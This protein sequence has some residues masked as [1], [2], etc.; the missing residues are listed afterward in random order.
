MS[1]PV[2]ATAHPATAGVVTL[3]P[4][5]LSGVA[6]MISLCSAAFTAYL[7][8]FRRPSLEMIVSRQL[9][10][11][12]AANEGLVINAGVTF[13]NSGAKYGVVTSI[14]GE[15]TKVGDENAMRFQWSKF[16]SYENAA[17]VGEGFKP[18]GSFSGWADHLVIPNRQAVANTIQFLSDDAFPL[19]AGK[20][21]LK[22]TAHF[23]SGPKH[24]KLAETRIEFDVSDSK[25]ETL[26]V[27]RVDPETKIS[28]ASVVFAATHV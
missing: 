15:L 10:T 3:M 6:I 17:P 22:L 21:Q 20:Y 19:Q 9:R 26:K 11:W 28:K 5:V 25:L 1:L 8:Y 27:T 4:L 13:T 12:I 14:S 24:K 18:H 23:G 2:P 7:Q 16:I